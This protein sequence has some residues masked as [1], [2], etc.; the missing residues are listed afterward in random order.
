M[1]ESGGLALLLEL[2][3]R[4]VRSWW[5]VIAGLCVG[6]AGGMRALDYLPQTYF[7]STKILVSP[8]TI[9]PDLVRS[10]SGDD[11]AFRFAA[12]KEEVL[13]RPYMLTLIEK[14]YGRQPSEAATE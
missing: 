6:L 13:S 3:D 2:A 9:P 5:T 8:P 14:T 1:N 11:M 7:A 4:L 12:L 10:A